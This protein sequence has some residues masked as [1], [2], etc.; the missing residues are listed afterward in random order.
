MPCLTLCP[1]PRLTSQPHAGLCFLE[2][3]LPDG[4]HLHDEAGAKEAAT[5]VI[6][7]AQ[8]ASLH[9]FVARRFHLEARFLALPLPPELASK[10]V[11]L[12]VRPIQ[13]YP[14]QVKE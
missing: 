14:L 6:Q 12:L 1:I 11:P 8:P 10:P 4:V 9:R 5:E 7:D 13:Q 2:K 3:V